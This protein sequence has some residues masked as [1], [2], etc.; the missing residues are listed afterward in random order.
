MD[1]PRGGVH[2]DFARPGGQAELSVWAVRSSIIHKLFGT[3]AVAVAAVVLFLLGRVLARV[4]LKISIPVAFVVGYVVLALVLLAF[5]GLAGLLAWLVIVAISE[6]LRR[7][8]AHI[9]T[10]KP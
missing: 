2:L 5:A 9:V 1:L 10:A 3:A 6:L 7:K 4:Q 8:L